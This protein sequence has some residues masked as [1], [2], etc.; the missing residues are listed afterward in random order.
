MVFLF[1]FLVCFFSPPDIA[2]FPSGIPVET[3]QGEVPGFSRVQLCGRDRGGGHRLHK[4][5]Q[6]RDRSAVSPGRIV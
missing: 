4:G 6:M 2:G 1:L 3:V 5:V